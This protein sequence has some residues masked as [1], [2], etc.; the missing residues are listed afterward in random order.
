M[1]SGNAAVGHGTMGSH[2]HGVSGTPGKSPK[3]RHALK[4]EAEQNER[5]AHK[6]REDLYD[7]PSDAIKNYK[8]R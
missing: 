4:R 1:R 7:S 6:S 3:L 2:K 5:K 8:L